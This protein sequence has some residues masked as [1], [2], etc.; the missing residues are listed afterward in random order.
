MAKPIRATPKLSGKDATRFIN[1]MI[2]L[3]KSKVSKADKELAKQ[4][5]ANS[6]FFKIY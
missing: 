6:K 4:I 5:E 3:E 2:C 1:K